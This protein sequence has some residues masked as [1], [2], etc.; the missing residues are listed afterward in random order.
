MF[1]LFALSVIP[2]GSRP[3]EKSNNLRQFQKRIWVHNYFQTSPDPDLGALL[4]SLFFRIQIWAHCDFQTFPDLDLGARQFSIFFQIQIRAHNDFQ[5]FPAP[6]LGRT[7]MFRLS[8]E[9][10]WAH[11]YFQ[12]LFRFVGHHRTCW[13]SFFFFR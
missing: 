13:K 2:N 4:F 8:P 11:N 5:T 9:P 6:G 10:V 1:F 12:T 7:N 3:I